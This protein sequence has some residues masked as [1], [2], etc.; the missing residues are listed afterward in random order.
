MHTRPSLQSVARTSSLPLL[1]RALASLWSD[2]G[3][4]GRG[5]PRLCSP[6]FV[7]A[8]A[9]AEPPSSDLVASGWDSMLVISGRDSMPFTENGRNRRIKNRLDVTCH[10]AVDSAVDS[11]TTPA[12]GDAET[13]LRC[14]H[15]N[16]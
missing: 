4:R 13:E 2:R 11:T 7:N 14:K 12:F 15:L 6:A 1:S 3:L 16:V 8:D 10:A 9:G 5:S